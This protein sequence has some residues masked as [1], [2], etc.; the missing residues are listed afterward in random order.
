M[1]R[2]LQALRRAALVLG[3]LLI[4]LMCA[5][6]AHADEFVRMDEAARKPT[7]PNPF[8]I[9]AYG[10]MWVAVLAYVA[11]VARGLSRGR[12]EVEELRKKVAGLSG[13]RG[14]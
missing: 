12:A 6:A 10:F 5:T 13:S 4:T 1:I 8:I 14:S 2:I 3:P 7:D 9:G 11:F